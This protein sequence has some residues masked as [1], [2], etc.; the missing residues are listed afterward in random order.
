ME[1][2]IEFAG[3]IPADK[4][5]TDIFESA[6]AGYI[7]KQDEFFVLKLEFKTQQIS[8]FGLDRVKPTEKLEVYTDIGK[9]LVSIQKLVPGLKLKWVG[10]QGDVIDEMT[11]LETNP[12]LA[13]TA[14]SMNY[15]EQKGKIGS[16]AEGKEFKK[17]YVEKIED[18]EKR[19]ALPPPPAKKEEPK[20][21]VIPGLDEWL[22]DIGFKDN[23]SKSISELWKLC[24]KKWSIQ[25]IRERV[26]SVLI[27]D[28]T[29]KEKFRI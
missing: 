18:V 2:E 16:S 26:G 22:V 13:G 15:I 25:Q 19:P 14:W 4:P 8:L 17:W 5:F 21:E 27:E 7:G 20:K 28:P 10:M 3:K 24:D 11:V 12:N 9:A 29:Q 6:H 1:Y 23:K